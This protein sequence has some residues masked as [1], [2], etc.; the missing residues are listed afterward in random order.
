MLS[1]SELLSQF[2]QT[3][4]WARY[5][6][7]AI[8]KIFSMIIIFVQVRYIKKKKKRKAKFSDSSIM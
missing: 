3:F 4:E 2:F 8:P 5:L 1:D 6:D 7:V